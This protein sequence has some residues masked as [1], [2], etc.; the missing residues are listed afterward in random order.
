[1][2][3]RPVDGR[4]ELAVDDGCGGGIADDARDQV[5]D[6]GYRGTSSRTPAGP[7]LQDVQT[8]RAGLGLAIFKGIVEAHRVNVLLENVHPLTLPIAGCCFRVRLPAR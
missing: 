6:V 8:S 4:V 2:L 1:M 3:G 5:S 7:E